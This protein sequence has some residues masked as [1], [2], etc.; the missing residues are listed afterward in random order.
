MQEQNLASLIISIIILIIVII[1]IIIVCCNCYNNNY[2]NN[3]YYGNQPP[4]PRPAALAAVAYQYGKNRGYNKNNFGSMNNNNNND[5]NNGQCYKGNT[6][7]LCKTIVN[8]D[9]VS[10]TYN[11]K[12]GVHANCLN[13]AFCSPGQS[14]STT[15]GQAGVCLG[16][17]QCISNNFFK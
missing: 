17:D 11:G 4:S 8:F 9:G 13:W 14:C 1:L 15:Y 3:Y 2:G 16:S 5:N 10:Y 7:N 12:C 6:G